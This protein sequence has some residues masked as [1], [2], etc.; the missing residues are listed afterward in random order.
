MVHIALKYN[1]A[2]ILTKH[3]SYQGTYQELIQPVF[4]HEGNTAALFLYDDT[5]E[6]DASIDEEDSKMI[7]A[8]LWSDRT[9]CQ[10]QKGT[11]VCGQTVMK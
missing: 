7:F 6:I 4:H 11:L 9:L 3:W 5:L 8:I 10:P 2:D 1:F